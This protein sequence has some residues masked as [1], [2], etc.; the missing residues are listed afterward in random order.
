MMHGQLNSLFQE[1]IS[2]FPAQSCMLS[3]LRAE[4]ARSFLERISSN[5][6]SPPNSNLE[7]AEE[8]IKPCMHGC[9]ENRLR[10]R[11]EGCWHLNQ[12]LMCLDK[13]RTELSES[14]DANIMH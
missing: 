12:L 3:F 2:E 8:G 13:F 5:F 1:S 4:L 6:L 10:P 9:L 14:I 11:A 7:Y